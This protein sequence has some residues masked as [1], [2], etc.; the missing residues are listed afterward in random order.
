[1]SEPNILRMILFIREWIVSGEIVTSFVGSNDQWF[2]IFTKA[3]RGPKIIYICNKFD[4]C[5][6]HLEWEY[7][8][9]I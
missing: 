3:L 4:A 6:L 9:T 1:M 5:M 8:D 2:D 7:C